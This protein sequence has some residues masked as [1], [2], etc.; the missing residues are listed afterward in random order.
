MVRAPREF[1][2]FFTQ[3]IQRGRNISKA[4]DEFTEVINHSNEP[5]YVFRRLG[6][7]KI[8]N[9]LSTLR[10]D[11]DSVSRDV[12]AHEGQPIRS[13]PDLIRVNR[14]PSRTQPLLNLTQMNQMFLIIG[15][16]NY[17]IIKVVIQE[18]KLNVVKTPVQYTSQ[19]LRAGRQSKGDLVELVQVPVGTES[20]TPLGTLGQGDLVMR[21]VQIQRRK[22][23]GSTEPSKCRVNIG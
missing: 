21:L 14:Q 11:R 10:I 19:R 20:R 7:R 9:G 3:G 17:Q 23:S 12:I 1:Y 18:L 6:W 22:D 4:R 16:I 13:E 8:Q 2:P 5:C 15:T